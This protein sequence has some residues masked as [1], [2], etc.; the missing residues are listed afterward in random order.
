M[1]N[2]LTGVAA[3]ATGLTGLTV[4]LSGCGPLGA[5]TYHEDRRYE[6]SGG[7]KGL[8]LRLDTADV[9]IVGTD[10]DRISVHERLSWSKR[11]KPTTEHRREG[12]TLR[13][14][15]QCPDVFSIG[16]QN[17][18]VDYR[19]QVPRAMAVKLHSDTG[20]IRI[21]GLAGAVQ[22]DADTGDIVATDLRGATVN[23]TADTGNILVSG[24]GSVQARADSGNVELLDL[25]G[26][27][28]VA[29]ADSG[30]VVIAFVKDRPPTLVQARADSGNVI[31]RLPG[32]FSYALTQHAEGSPRWGS[33]A[34]AA[35][36]PAAGDL[37]IDPASPRKVFV[38]A[39]SGTVT[40][41]PV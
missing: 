34:P 18:E 7:L 1:A 9:E 13:L 38:S 40:V 12:D 22:A 31:V 14:R 29:T 25:R 4:A 26:E 30:N 39:D 36:R 32:G 10:T 23:V 16:F 28:A 41:S 35:G 8:D 19:I 24:A 21:R 6:V 5:T 15:Y 33:G 27:R 37:T 3:L 20:R 17:C 2:R 11:L